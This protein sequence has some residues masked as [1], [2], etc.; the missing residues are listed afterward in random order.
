MEASRA[1]T[2]GNS[3][4]ALVLGICGLV[5]FPPIGIL[6]VIFGNR[7]RREIASRAEEGSGLAT[8]G[9]ILGWIGIALTALFVLAVVFF[10][11]AVVAVGVSL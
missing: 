4:T 10:V 2:N 11:V 1:P 7:A 5:V 3:I 8:A 9:V 6:A